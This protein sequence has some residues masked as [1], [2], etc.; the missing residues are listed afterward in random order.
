MPTER[1]AQSPAVQSAYDL[2]G[3]DDFS[4]YAK[5]RI[6]QIASELG[7]TLHAGS[8]EATLRRCIR[9]YQNTGW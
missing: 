4:P 2:V 7:I 9:A 1:P 6:D 3:W 8:D 5:Q